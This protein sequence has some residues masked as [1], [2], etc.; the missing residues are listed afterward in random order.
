MFFF[1]LLDLCW[2]AWHGA[3][4]FHRMLF[5]GFLALLYTRA[6]LFKGF[7]NFGIWGIFH[8]KKGLHCQ[9]NMKFDY[10]YISHRKNIYSWWGWCLNPGKLES[11]EWAQFISYLET[12]VQT[13]VPP[14]PGDWHHSAWESHSWTKCGNHWA[15]LLHLE[16]EG[17]Q[18][19][20]QRSL[21]L[22]KS[23][24]TGPD[25]IVI[26]GTCIHGGQWGLEPDNTYRQGVL[27][28]FS[29]SICISKCIS[30]R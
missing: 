6:A 7:I 21:G 19:I 18:V 25:M 2:P 1:I 28:D 13:F 12:F 16:K 27:F 9:T 23:P 14:D 10:Q 26:L 11:T 22:L 3:V 8:L 29:P 30:K 15:Q 5:W 4:N 17:G 24:H 20:H